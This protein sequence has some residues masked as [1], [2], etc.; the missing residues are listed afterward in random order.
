MADLLLQETFHYQLLI[1]NTTMKRRHFLTTGAGSLAVGALG[2]SALHSQIAAEKAE[3]QNSSRSK[4][5]PFK[6]LFAPNPGHFDNTGSPQGYLA[7]MQ[8]AS[9]LGFRAWED[10]GLPGRGAEL[11]AAMGRFLKENGMTMGV[12]VVS[13]GG[14]FVFADATKQEEQRLLDECKKTVE[15]ANHVGH[16]WFTLV[17]GARDSKSPIEEQIKGA[18]PLI[19]KCCDI[20]EEADLIFVVE[21][22]SH[23]MG[24]KPVLLE[25]FQEGNLLCK[26][27]NR[28]SCKLLADYYHQQQMGGNLIK[29]TD[30]YWDE[31]AYVQ[32]GD[33]PGRRQPGTGEINYTNV[34]R[35]LVEKGYQGVIGLEHGIQ[36]NLDDLLRAYRE[37]DSAL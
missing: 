6:V 26:E 15:V 16:K 32:Y 22:L 7:A 31:I 2:T 33:V 10:N 11:H 21:P 1:A 17:P 8:K 28:P 30:Q 24:G 9:D 14:G 3:E 36:G 18:A 35:H 37:I 5:D 4:E 27:V 20:F 12:S 19:S 25:T 13:T 23:R 34:T 29:N